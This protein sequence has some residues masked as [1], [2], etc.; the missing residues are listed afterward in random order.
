MPWEK[1]FNETEVLEKA[2]QVF[3]H[4]GYSAT[5]LAELVKCTGI[6]RGSLYATYRDKHTLFVD[7]LKL[8][9]NRMR[10]QML[11]ELES[12]HSPR[13][14]I[15][16]LFLKFTEN[17]SDRGGNRGCFLTNTALELSAHDREVA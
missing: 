17:V 14:A 5:S 1:Q 2:M 8:Y 9:V 16:Q 7:A 15:H 4:R 10:D 3:W 12:R 13:E 11:P 6:G